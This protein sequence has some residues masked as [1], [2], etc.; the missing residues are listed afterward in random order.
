M[1]NVTV[2]AAFTAG[3]ISF[4]SPCV[5]P[6]IPGY[7]SFISGVSLEEMKGGDRK[8]GALKK[9]SLNTLLFVLGFSFVFTAMGASATFIGEF[10]L[11]KLALFNKIAGV[12]IVVLGLHIMGLFRISFLNYE[13]RF[14]TKTKPLG[15]LGSFVVGLAFA[16]GWT[17]CIGPILGGILL[18]ASNQDTVGKGIVLLS[19]YSLGLGIPFFI[20][21]VSFNTFLGVFGWVKKHFRTVEI[22]SGL[23]LVTI[24]FLIFIGSFS[25]VAGLFNQW[26]LPAE[27]G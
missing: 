19:S 10:L 20:T 7:L 26:F 25:Y 21:A 8:S 2:L 11:S 4:I 22:V 6:L 12:I 1:E 27:G 17:P 14:H 9:V 5:L 13:K 23:L 15:P 3:I 16:F 18:L 24:G